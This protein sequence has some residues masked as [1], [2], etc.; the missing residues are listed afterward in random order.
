V[1]YVTCARR[2]KSLVHY[3]TSSIKVKASWAEAIENMDESALAFVKDCETRWSGIFCMLKRVLENH[4]AIYQYVKQHNDAPHLQLPELKLLRR[5]VEILEP[6]EQLNKVRR[7]CMSDASHVTV[8][9]SVPVYVGVCVSEACAHQTVHEKPTHSL[10]AHFV[11]V[12]QML[13]GEGVTLSRVWPS[14]M[15]LI[16]FVMPREH[17]EDDAWHEELELIQELRQALYT[18]LNERWLAPGSEAGAHTDLYKLATALDPRYF[19]DCNF[20]K[21]KPSLQALVYRAIEERQE[22]LKKLVAE[23]KG[24]EFGGWGGGRQAGGRGEARA[25]PQAPRPQQAPRAF[26]LGGNRVAVGVALGEGAAKEREAVD[27]FSAM[28]DAEVGWLFANAGV[29]LEADP[30]AWWELNRQSRPI[31]YCLA[32]VVLAVPASAAK[33]ERLFSSAGITYTKHRSSLKGDRADKL[34]VVKSNWQS[35]LFKRFP[36][37]VEEEE[38][39]KAEAR[40]KQSASG[41]KAHE[42][43]RKAL[44]GV[45]GQASKKKK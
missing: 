6:F 13:Q 45:D 2:V 12:M 37:E 11:V 29:D 8:S 24:P 9:V 33:I 26:K 21:F 7:L 17:D 14:I 28:A 36:W 5:L 30:M 20:V 10:R 44:L 38:R 18:R 42:Q 27:L 35:E 41:K 25:A 32:K 16:D 1:S 23:L 40:E 22:L 34:L 19:C 39:K 3:Y 31:L 43:K 15:D 4:D